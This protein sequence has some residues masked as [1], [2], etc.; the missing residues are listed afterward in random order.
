[1]HRVTS[2]LSMHCCSS[3][4]TSGREKQCLNIGEIVLK[5]A[6]H[7]FRIFIFAQFFSSNPDLKDS[8]NVSSKATTRVSSNALSN[9]LRQLSALGAWAALV[10]FPS[11]ESLMSRQQPPSFNFFDISCL[12]CFT[13]PITLLKHAWDNMLYMQH[14]EGETRHKTMTWSL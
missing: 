3:T 4:Y 7:P 14:I 12:G 11:F 10:S 5:V 6:P 2:P 1:M 13:R 8:A 9:L